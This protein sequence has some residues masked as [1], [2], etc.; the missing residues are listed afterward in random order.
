MSSLLPKVTKF[1]DPHLLVSYLAQD[2][3]DVNLSPTSPS[4]GVANFNRFYNQFSGINNYKQKQY[5]YFGIEFSSLHN[6][7]FQ[8]LY[9]H[10]VCTTCIIQYFSQTY[11]KYATEISLSSVMLLAMIPPDIV[12][13]K[14]YFVRIFSLQFSNLHYEAKSFEKWRDFIVTLVTGQT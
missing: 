10:V 1:L 14:W 4:D 6:H 13:I 12:V 9:S 3:K 8:T 2:R 11:P 7:I 5:Q